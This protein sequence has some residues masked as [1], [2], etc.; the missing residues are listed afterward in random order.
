M[1]FYVASCFQNKDI[2]RVVSGKI[3]MRGWHRTYDWTQNER[4][5]SLEA[6]K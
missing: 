2:V 3:T 6:L 4:A 5:C 1:K